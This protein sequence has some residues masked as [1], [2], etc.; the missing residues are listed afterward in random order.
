MKSGRIQGSQVFS[1]VPQLP[2]ASWGWVCCWRAVTYPS[3]SARATR[4]DDGSLMLRACPSFND[5]CSSTASPK[6]KLFA[7]CAGDDLLDTYTHECGTAYGRLATWVQGQY[8]TSWRRLLRPN[9][10]S[11]PTMTQPPQLS[12]R[13]GRLNLIWPQENRIVSNPY[14]NP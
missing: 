14:S 7:M 1:C 4:S 8:G 11:T 6:V 9:Q 2:V 10:N 3:D 12:I 5:T 13:A